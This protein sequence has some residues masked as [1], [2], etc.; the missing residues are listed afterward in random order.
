MTAFD[1]PTAPNEA[2]THPRTTHRHGTYAC[3]VLDG[4]RCDDCRPVAVAY[5]REESRRKSYR[6]YATDDRYEPYVDASRARAHVL[7]LQAAGLG[8]KQIA[9]RAGTG[10]SAIGALLYPTPS[11]GRGVRTKISR[12]TEAKLLAVAIPS[13]EEL[14]A[15]QLIDGTPTRN[16]IQ[17]LGRMGYSVGEISRVARVDRQRLDK[18]MKGTPTASVQTHIA[19]RDVFT[20]LWRTPCTPVEWRAKIAATRTRRR[21]IDLGWPS[22]IDLDDDGYLTDSPS[23]CEGPARGVDLD[24]FA[25]LL[26]SGETPERAASRLGVKLDSINTAIARHGRSDIAVLLEAVAA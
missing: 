4:C 15:H 18:I 13:P 12:E 2:C 3:Y 17:A 19:V 6:R 11:R 23:P 9:K 24:E 8:Y 5:R 21:A 25:F 7:A 22:P 10:C 20:R 26:R 16:R 1:H 14:A